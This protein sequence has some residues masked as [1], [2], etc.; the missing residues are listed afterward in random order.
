MARHVKDIKAEKK[1]EYER[2][3]RTPGTPE[4]NARQERLDQRTRV[5]QREQDEAR[6]RLRREN[7]ARSFAQTRAAVSLI[8]KATIPA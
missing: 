8:K 6:A 2:L 1:A 4:H 5:L 3:C 7:A